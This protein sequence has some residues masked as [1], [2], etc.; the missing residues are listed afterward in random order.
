MKELNNSQKIL[1]IEESNNMQ[2]SLQTLK[3][4]KNN[5]DPENKMDNLL[6]KIQ[7]SILMV[8]EKDDLANSIPL[9]AFCFAIS[10]ILNGFHDCKIHENEDPLLYSTILLFGGVGQ[11]T[12][13]IFE[14]IKSRTFPSALYFT[15]GLYFLSLYLGKTNENYFNDKNQRFFYGS[16]ACLTFPIYI[17]SF[18]TNI[19]L[20][21]QNLSIIGF[22]I[23]KC[24]GNIYD[25]SSMKGIIAG[26]LELVSGFISLYICFGQILNEHF[27]FQL[28]PSI[29]F[30]KGNDI[31]DMK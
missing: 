22:F 5:G 23:I 21:L 11:I 17:G 1:K 27:R 16:W 7:K 3:K 25:V 9:G 15:Y 14:Y 10:F 26:I 20:S 6:T 24:I 4:D 29:P 18:K 28:F 8:E 31:D 12:T 19:F 13:G 2:D 30:N